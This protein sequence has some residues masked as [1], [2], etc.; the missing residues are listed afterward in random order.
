[1][2]KVHHDGG[3]DRFTV[4]AGGQVL[5]NSGGRLLVEAGAIM[6]AMP[7]WKTFPLTAHAISPV[8]GGSNIKTTNANPVSITIPLGL[9]LS[10][11]VIIW[12]YGAG[13]VTFVEG[14][15]S[16]HIRTPETLISSKQFSGVMLTP[17][18]VADEYVLAGF[19]EAA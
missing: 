9:I 17:T 7:H 10:A 2:G 16:V 1:M 15:P 19:L 6:E 8:D 11:P 5:V 12:Q 14:S 18:D 4:E 3:G 13:Q